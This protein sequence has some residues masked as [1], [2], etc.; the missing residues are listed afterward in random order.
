MAQDNAPTLPPHKLRRIGVI[1]D[2]HCEDRRLEAALRFLAQREINEILVETGPTLSGALVEAELVDELIVYIAPKLL[3]DSGR[4]LVTLPSVQHLAKAVDL[5]IVD[6]R[7]LGC[8]W[9]IS[10]RLK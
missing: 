10:A 7:S 4:G 8:D 2:I 6:V 9:R 1:G 3:G 5:Q